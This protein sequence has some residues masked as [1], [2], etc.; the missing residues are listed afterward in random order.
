ML[1][2]ILPTAE[3]IHHYERECGEVFIFLKG[4]LRELVSRLVMVSSGW[5]FDHYSDLQRSDDA[6]R[7]TADIVE[8][9][10]VSLDRRYLENTLS[11]LNVPVYIE[12]IIDEIDIALNR[13]M[14][15]YFANVPYK[16]HR[17]VGWLGNELVVHMSPIGHHHGN[18]PTPVHYSLF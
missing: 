6:H 12:S 1:A 7:V 4:G 13:M 10:E 5:Y 9:Y 16:V 3:I 2:V 11:R 15:F 17:T 8:E 14:N 18:H